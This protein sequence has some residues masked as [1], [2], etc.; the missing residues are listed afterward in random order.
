[1]A[2]K[3]KQELNEL[4][5][6]LHVDTL[7][8]WSRYHCYKQD[9]YEYFLKYVIHEP[10]DRTNSIYCVSGGNVHEIIEQLYTDQIKYED[11]AELYEDSLFT[12]NCAELKYNRSDSEKNEAIADKYENCIR[13][14]FKHHNMITSPHFVEK[15]ITIKISD[16]IYM[17]G[18]I[19][20]L[21]VEKYFDE[22][23]KEKTKVRVLD[24][25]TSTLYRGEK[26]NKECGQLVLY[27]EGIRQLLN[28]PLENIECEW[29]FLK[30]VTVTI[31]Q[32]NGKKK[33]R[34]IERNSIGESLINTAKMW[35]KYFGYEENLDEYVDK[36]VLDN[37]V[38]CLPDEVREKIKIQDCYVQVPLSEEKI[39]DLK[40]DII[41]TIHDIHK[42]EEE[43]RDTHD[44]KTFWQEVTAADE[45]R[46][47]TLSGYSR[48]KHKPYDSYLK[49]KELFLNK[50]NNAEDDE[51]IDFIN[52]L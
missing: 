9:T 45:F 42:K 23:K 6:T 14:F 24:W 17:Q 20:M 44:E 32:K 51:L 43:Y 30:Y 5:K 3:T 41:S 8:S 27:A 34:Y 48:K 49:Q 50:E 40:N 13:H 18:Y 2:R 19:D 25:K 10:E 21:V 39:T 7:W 1:M 12:M 15:F 26:I 35:L 28:I 22:N 11:M 52:S 29:N 33:D 31:E 4:C 47:A 36:M 16:D 38:E 37:D 46:L